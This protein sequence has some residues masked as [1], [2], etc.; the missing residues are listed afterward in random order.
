MDIIVEAVYANGALKLSQAL[1]LQENEKVQVTVHKPVT[2]DDAVAAV[3]RGYG[4]IRW[5]GD[6]EVLRQLAEGD[7]FGILESS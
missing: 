6:P 5:T 1:P 4:L 3:Q 2:R 7:E